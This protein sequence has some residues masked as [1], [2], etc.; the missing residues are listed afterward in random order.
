MCSEHECILHKSVDRYRPVKEQLLAVGDIPIKPIS[1]YNTNN[2]T[3]VTVSGVA[4][5]YVNITRTGVEPNGL[6]HGSFST[7]SKSTYNST[8]PGLAGSA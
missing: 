7:S 5:K 6:S 4:R 8:G 2:L 3:R 1:P